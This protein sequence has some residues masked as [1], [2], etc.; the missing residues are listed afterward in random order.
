[1]AVDDGEVS[2]GCNCEGTGFVGDRGV[3]VGD[4]EDGG[5]GEVVVPN[6]DVAIGRFSGAEEAELEDGGRGN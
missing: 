3:A 2:I 6:A 1:M 5:G 4:P